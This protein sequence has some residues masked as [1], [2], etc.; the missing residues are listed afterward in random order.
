MGIAEVAGLGT[1]GEGIAGT[2]EYLALLALY[3][4]GEIVSRPE[5]VSTGGQ[6][7]H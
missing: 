5:T 6:A 7:G 2:A 4:R 1:L 3:V